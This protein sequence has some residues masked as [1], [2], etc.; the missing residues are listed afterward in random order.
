MKDD[1]RLGSWMVGLGLGACLAGLV[2][3][4]IRCNF[5]GIWDSPPQL[6]L[7]VAS[8][9]PALPPAT[10]K[11]KKN[12][13]RHGSPSTKAG[14]PQ[15]RAKDKDNDDI[16]AASASGIPTAAPAEL[17][18][19][20]S[21][22]PTRRIL[23][24][25]GYVQK[26][27]GVIEAI[28]SEGEGVQVVHVGDTYQDRF[29]VAQISPNG[30]EIVGSATSAAE[31]SSGAQVVSVA[32]QLN[33]A[34]SGSWSYSRP[35]KP[36]EKGARS[37]LLESTKANEV[38]EHVRAIPVDNIA[39]QSTTA[40]QG[41]DTST[42]QVKSST[43]NAR[44]LGFVEKYDGTKVS[45]MADGEWVRLQPQKGNASELAS[46]NTSG[47]VAEMAQADPTS[48]KRI[49]AP[50]SFE[51][52]QAND[53]S[54]QPHP[55]LVSRSSNAA[56]SSFTGRDESPSSSGSGRTLGYVEKAQG[57]FQAIVDKDG[58]VQ[59]AQARNSPPTI[60]AQLTSP[61]IPIDLSESL[62]KRQSPSPDSEKNIGP[63]LESALESSSYPLAVGRL[64]SNR[65]PHQGQRNQSITDSIPPPSDSHESQ[66]PDIEL[67]MT[68]IEAG[69]E[70]PPPE[71]IGVE[72][73][74]SWES[75]S[76][77]STERSAAV[78]GSL[79][80]LG[81]QRG[82]ASADLD[83]YEPSAPPT[84]PPTSDANVAEAFGYGD[85]QF[86]RA[87]PI[88]NMT[89]L[90][91]DDVGSSETRS[92]F[93]KAVGYLEWPDGRAFAV[94]ED[95]DGGVRLIHEGQ[96][97]DQRYRVLKITPDTVEVLELPV[98]KHTSKATPESFAP[99]DAVTGAM[100][101]T[102]FS[103]GTHSEVSSAH[104]EVPSPILSSIVEHEGMPR[105]GQGMKLHTPL[106]P[107]AIV[108]KL[109]SIPGYPIGSHQSK[110]ISQP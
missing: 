5:G 82:R 86:G 13:H 1:H 76:D 39:I 8:P 73:S 23:K 28:V 61:A 33:G 85:W 11:H 30:V 110:V 90:K 67:A 15:A 66:P 29:K 84:G 103:E 97:L 79:G 55:S 65:T 104:I 43:S 72:A 69:S 7:D 25:L 9:Q 78:L 98:V 22:E 92:I 26:A 87:S 36:A 62:V 105:N 54:A 31:I 70:K 3:V 46:N 51:G 89:A 50:T 53:L 96:V 48:A 4:G 2:Y 24:P 42:G 77:G 57:I 47:R 18:R 100:P 58:D 12:V 64:A 63:L 27:D 45:V 19:A 99:S 75:K 74:L 71:E 81:D 6:T 93:L 21:N 52:P 88:S 80:I 41:I 107:K 101:H 44:P 60:P 38:P 14:T 94:V 91:S 40:R 56:S 16:L 68:N 10:S 102:T 109:G 32:N 83:R 20:N 106:L 108:G 49:Q 17:T 59:L 95:G 37:E 34:D 35:K